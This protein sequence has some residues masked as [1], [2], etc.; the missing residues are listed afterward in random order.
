M[1]QDPTLPR[2]QRGKELVR[3]GF[4]AP[5]WTQLGLRPVI[6]DPEDQQL[7]MPGH[8]WQQA[9]HS[10]L[11][12]S[13]VRRR[14]GETEQALLRSQG[15]PL[16]GVPL[17]C[18]PTSALARF[19]S[20]LFRVLLFRCL[21]LP[22]PPPSRICRCGRLLD[23]F[24]HHHAA[25]AEAGVLGRRGFAFESAAARVCR[26][27]GARVG[28]NILVRDLDLVPQ[29]RPDSR[30][31]EV[32]ADGLPLFHGAQLAIDTTHW[33]P[34]WDETVCHVH[35]VPG[36]WS[37]PHHRQ[38]KKRENVSR[39]DW[40]IWAGKARGPRL[41]SGRE[42]SE[43]QWFKARARTEPV[44]HQTR[45]AWLRRWMTISACSSAS[46]LTVSTGSERRWGVRWPNSIH[47][48]SGGEHRFFC[49]VC[50]PLRVVRSRVSLFSM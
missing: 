34:Q 31:L 36:G 3:I 43:T 37:S 8:G 12:E 13:Q 39:V 41:R 48:R 9:V 46:V 44:P 2:Q 29:G 1:L 16:S 27:A 14:L 45:A 20:A 49:G 10:H 47:C 33:C 38:K 40:S 17:S 28:T 5:S 32:V 22:L 24:G 7:G 50:E 42:A 26:E 11:V 35:V 21:W 4:V 15:G 18:F 30:R 6:L 19:D 23:V 25:C